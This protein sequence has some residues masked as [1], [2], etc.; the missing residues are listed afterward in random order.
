MVLLSLTK[1]VAWD[2]VALQC[3]ARPSPALALQE[4]VWFRDGQR[5]PVA[6]LL[7]AI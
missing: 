2:R 6:R 4:I 1:V 7:I 5:L 3:G